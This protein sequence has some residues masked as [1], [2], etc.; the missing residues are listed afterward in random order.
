MELNEIKYPSVVI[1]NVLRVWKWFP[2]FIPNKVLNEGEAQLKK[3][4]QQT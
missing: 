4:K 3:L 2:N 1:D